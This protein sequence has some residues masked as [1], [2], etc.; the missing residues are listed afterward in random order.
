MAQL[1]AVPASWV[2][3]GL[4]ISSAGVRWLAAARHHT[5]WL[6]QD[7]YA[8]AALARGLVATGKFSVR[9]ADVAF[10]ALLQPLL[11]AP[12]WLVEDPAVALRLT[13][14][15]NAVAFSLVA[16]PVYLLARHLR[17]STAFALS[18]AVLA[19][20]LPGLAY[21]S[22][23][24]AEPIATPL[25]LAAFYAGVR[26]LEHTTPRSELLF[27]ALASLATF[28]RIQYAFLP[29]AL[30]AAALILEG[31][32]LRRVVS[33]FRLTLALLGFV[34][35]LGALA[36]PRRI[37]G[38]Y[39]HFP[40]DWYSPGPILHWVGRSLMLLG[41]SAGWV[42]VPG[43]VAA[44]LAAVLPRADLRSRAFSALFFPTMA[45][46]LL[47]A[48][49]FANIS[50]VARFEERYLLMLPPL[51]AIAFGLSGRGTRE[52]WLVVVVA[53]GMLLLSARLTLSA[54]SAAFGADAS[55]TLWALTWLEAALGIAE[56]SLSF[57]AAAGVL[58]LVAV[59]AVLRP[60][61]GRP[62]ALA[63]AF[64]A[65][66][67]LSVGAHLHDGAT[68]DRVRVEL[69]GQQARWVDGH[70][71]AGATLVHAPTALPYGALLQLFWNRTIDRV[72]LLDGADHFDIFATVTAT[73]DES[74]RLVDDGGLISRPLLFDRALQADLLEAQL[75]QREAGFELWVPTGLARI[76]S[77]VTGAYSDGWLGGEGTVN[78]WPDRSG[79]VRG[80]L[81]LAL[82]LPAEA[83]P[84]ALL[85]SGHGVSR[86]VELEPGRSTTVRI[87]V[88]TSRPYEL[89][90]QSE[91][92]VVDRR[93]RS[94][95]ARA[96]VTF[97]R[98]GSE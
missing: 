47:Q 64:V 35:V 97:T 16:I 3:A 92:V 91:K 79:R 87:A 6:L 67:A 42:L 36:D 96:V 86:R 76:S 63:C 93:L 90:F 30:L 55:P 32:S 70:S 43:A 26:A 68:A 31:G 59:L 9:G 85:L 2:L 52:R 15:F 89:S 34:L 22:F 72:A 5:P 44:L 39:W 50:P 18:A 7:E 4:V 41:Y 83:A 88:D 78:L 82:D 81:V 84:N 71:L 11:T 21:T 61:F 80:T 51:V 8:Y 29:L 58:S 49:L 28:A 98:Q 23:V 62:A 20:A 14:G 66:A 1:R 69:L 54:Y 40:A 48:S 10:P 95:S 94:I 24:L 12:A 65:A 33:K 60:R 27:A 13:Q 25:A 57:A 17:L 74:G 19:L 53:L 38:T 77:L 56:A 75:L 45:A 46:L 37:A 73:V